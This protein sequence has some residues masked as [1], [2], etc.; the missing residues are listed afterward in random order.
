MHYLLIAAYLVTGQSFV[1]GKFDTESKCIEAKQ[2]QQSA[3]P[4]CR[5]EY[6]CREKK[7]GAH[8]AKKG[9]GK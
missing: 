4:M 7:G 2:A 6:V 9:E 1:V 8:R 5:I 3:C